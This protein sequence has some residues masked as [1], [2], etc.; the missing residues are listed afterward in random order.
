MES[1]LKKDIIR[2]A[3]ELSRKRMELIEKHGDAY[4]EAADDHLSAAVVSLAEVCGFDILEDNMRQ[5]E[6]GT[7]SDIAGVDF[8]YFTAI[9]AGL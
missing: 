9:L 4:L 8:D 7:Q 6:K 5:Y 1:S 3:L 2:L